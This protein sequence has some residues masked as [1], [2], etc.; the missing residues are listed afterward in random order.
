MDIVY[1]NLCI[2]SYKPQFN[3]DVNNVDGG[4]GDDGDDDDNGNDD[5]DDNDY[6]VSCKYTL[7][8]SEMFLCFGSDDTCHTKHMF[9]RKLPCGKE[10]INYKRRY[11][12]REK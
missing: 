5:D 10:L 3:G 6:V 9:H 1:H 7:F 8:S 11:I 12:I 2:T 4:H